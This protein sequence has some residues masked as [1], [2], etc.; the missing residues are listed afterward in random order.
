MAN[1]CFARCAALRCAVPCPHC[2]SREL[3]FYTPPLCRPRGRELGYIVKEPLRCL[4]GFTPAAPPRRAK[5][6][7]RH[8]QPFPLE[9]TNQHPNHTSPSGILVGTGV[10]TPHSIIHDR[11]ASHK[12]VITSKRRAQPNLCQAQGTPQGKHPPQRLRV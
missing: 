8:H 7:R 1:Y 3:L 11:G 4:L 6:S 9:H 5:T 2:V 12:L 10:Q